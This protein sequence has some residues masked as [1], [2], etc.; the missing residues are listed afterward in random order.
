[1]R[2]AEKREKAWGGSDR[3]APPSKK[4]P[5]LGRD[6]KATTNMATQTVS[7]PHTGLG[8]FPPLGG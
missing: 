6:T 8:Q 3:T 4:M 1:M 2:E 7:S 5:P